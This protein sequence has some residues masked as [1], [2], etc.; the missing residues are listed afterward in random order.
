MAINAYVGIPGSGKTYEVVHSVILPA[1]LAGR[2]IC[3]QYR[4]D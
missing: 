3:N 1:F 2:R 4:G